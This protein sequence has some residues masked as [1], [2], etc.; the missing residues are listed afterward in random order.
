LW[1]PASDKHIM[2]MSRALD[3]VSF[4]YYELYVTLPKLQFFFN[5]RTNTPFGYVYLYKC[6]KPIQQKDK[7]AWAKCTEVKNI[8]GIR[9]ESTHF[10]SESPNKTCW[11]YTTTDIYAPIVE[12]WVIFFKAN[13]III[14]TINFYS[15]Q[16]R[17]AISKKKSRWGQRQQRGISYSALGGY[18]WRVKHQHSLDLFMFR[19]MLGSCP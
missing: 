4:F 3:L 18:K 2:G 1:Y 14:K 15:L 16:D 5:S 8:N 9:K 7:Y 6:F 17:S 13:K 12:R 11:N 19:Q 10:V